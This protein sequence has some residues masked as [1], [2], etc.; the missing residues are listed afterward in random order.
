MSDAQGISPCCVPTVVRAD[1]DAPQARRAY[2]APTALNTRG[3][4][5][6]PGGSF[7]M[8]TD[9]AEGF[10]HDGEGPARTVTLRPFHIDTCA[11]SNRQFAKFVQDTGYVTDAEKFGNSPVFYHFVAA[12]DAAKVKQRAGGAEWWWVIKGASWRHPE[13]LAS[14]I[15]ERM[16]H[17]VV[18]V[19]WNDA[20]AY[21]AWAGKRL[22]TEAEWEF[23]ARG[24]LS[25]ARYP[26]GDELVPGGV[27]HCNIWQG[28]FPAENTL[29]DG[30][31]G[32][33]PVR[34]FPPNGFG[35]FNMVGNTWEW[36]ADVWSAD[37]HQN[38]STDNPTGPPEGEARVIRGGS[39][40]CHA[41]YCNRYRVAA[42]SHNTPESATGHMGFRCAVDGE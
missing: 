35:L 33:A 14:N 23:A 42:R 21:C 2:A 19:S 1:A 13:V 26:W 6:L 36:C 22:P 5:R 10:A 41:S 12:A 17:P 28:N 29:E 31:A 37:F 4:K 20:Q 15:K 34:S 18:Q 24:R 38:A 8:G 11:V 7:V 40:L 25:G 30:Y 32:T 39:Y 9:S 16:D 27:H 3:M